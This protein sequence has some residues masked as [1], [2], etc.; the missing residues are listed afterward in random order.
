M[1]TENPL[2][3]TRNPLNTALAELLHAAGDCAANADLK[4]TGM[5]EGRLGPA[6]TPGERVMAQDTLVVKKER[7]GLSRV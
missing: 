2:K 3:P 5:D 6:R 4:Q 7:T 1:T